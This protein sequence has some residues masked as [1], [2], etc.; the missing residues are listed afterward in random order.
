MTSII[1]YLINKINKPMKSIY[2][3]REEPPGKK[4]S[5]SASVGS[6]PKT[7][8]RIRKGFKN[9]KTGEVTWGEE[10]NMTM[11]PSTKEEFFSEAKKK[12]GSQYILKNKTTKVEP[13][14]VLKN[15]LTKLK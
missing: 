6:Q 7:I 9:S 13:K 2:V 1:R 4:A 8:A 15:K 12:S 10:R 5:A 11:Q 14:Y 3:K